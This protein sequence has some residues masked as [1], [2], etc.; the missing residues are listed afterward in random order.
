M[1]WRKSRLS[2]ARSPSLPW[3]GMPPRLACGMP[4]AHPDPSHAGCPQL[5]QT[6]ALPLAILVS[7]CRT[8]IRSLCRILVSLCRTVLNLIRSLNK[9]YAVIGMHLQRSRP[10]LTFLAAW[11]DLLRED[12]NIAIR[13]ST[14]SDFVAT[15]GRP[16]QPPSSALI[17]AA[18]ACLGHRGHPSKF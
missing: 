17:L 4:S 13:S 1:R 2:N 7:L 11:N 18:A 16:H 12:L 14:S 5:T 3:L 15:T 8:F 6:R 9:K 10:F